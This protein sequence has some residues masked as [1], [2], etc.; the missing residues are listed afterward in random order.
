MGKR[1]GIF[2]G[3]F[4]PVHAGHIAFA[5]TT[6]KVARLDQVYFL[7]EVK[8]R[9]KTG[10]THVAHRAAMLH[11][12]IRPY[13]YFQVLD[14]PDRQFSVGGT[15]PRLN[16][17]FEHDQL[18]FMMGS[19][20]FSSLPEWELMEQLI[21][22]A[23]IVVG[24]RDGC[25]LHNIIDVANKLPYPLREFHIVESHKAAESSSRIRGLLGRGVNSGTLLSV[26]RYASQNWLYSSMLAL[27]RL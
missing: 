22:R 6:K 13:S 27:E 12:A 14:L 2:A 20:T 18:V 3:T 9:Y 21:K 11:L 7:P 19:D 5:V 8:P 23:G 16:R 15:L 1:I 25:S 17:Y 24:L 26:Q 10:V 4:D